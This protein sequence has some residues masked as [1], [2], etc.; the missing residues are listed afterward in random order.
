MTLSWEHL[1]RLERKAKKRN[2][3]MEDTWG[4]G[5]NSSSVIELQ[6][7]QDFNAFDTRFSLLFVR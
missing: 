6:D 4:G 1:S 7:M 5:E 2:K 3:I